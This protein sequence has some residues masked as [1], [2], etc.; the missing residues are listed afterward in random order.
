MHQSCQLNHFR[1]F[2]SN[3]HMTISFLDLHDMDLRSGKS[4]LWNKWWIFRPI[5]H[6]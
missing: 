4:K 1:Y 3:M 2:N 5:T 6:R